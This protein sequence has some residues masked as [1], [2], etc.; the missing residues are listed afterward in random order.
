MLPTDAPGGFCERR[1][2]PH[3]AVCGIESW[4]WAN[5]K[6]S[7]RLLSSRM[8]EEAAILLGQADSGESKEPIHAEQ[9]DSRMQCTVS[10]SR[11][12]CVGLHSTIRRRTAIDRTWPCLGSCLGSEINWTRPWSISVSP[13]R[14]HDSAYATV[15]GG[16]PLHFGALDEPG[17]STAARTSVRVAATGSNAPSPAAW[18]ATDGDAASR[19][20][21]LS[22]TRPRKPDGRRAL[23]R[24]FQRLR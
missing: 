2:A 9:R 13:A 17:A 6:T 10:D 16:K 22:P 7:G 5:V 4:T 18:A 12:S 20:S 24:R 14:Q 21:R 8:R 23:H 3:R 11:R 1:R 15:G 19:G